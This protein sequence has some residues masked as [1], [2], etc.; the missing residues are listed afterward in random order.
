MLGNHDHARR[1]EAHHPS[2]R[3]AELDGLR[4]VAVLMVI[5]GH[6]KSMLPFKGQPWTLFL[7]PTLG[8]VIFFVLSG[9]LITRLLLN[10]ISRTGRV[11]LASFYWRRA[12]RILPA[13]YVYLGI[14]ALLAACGLVAIS[15]GQLLVAFLHLWNY[16]ALILGEGHPLQGYRNLGHFWS[17]ALEEQYYWIWPLVLILF[18]RHSK[19]ILVTIIAVVPV[20]RVASYFLFPSV[21]GQLG[22]MFHTGIDA[23]SV[24]SLIAVCEKTL[25]TRIAKLPSKVISAAVVALM[26]AVPILY[27][28][29]KGPWT[30]TYGRTVESMLAGLVILALVYRPEHWL[31]R[32]LRTKPMQFIGTISFSL[33][34]WQTAFCSKGAVFAVHPALSLPGAFAAAILSYYAVEKPAS[35]L[36]HMRLRAKV[37]TLTSHG[38]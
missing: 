36:R 28:L 31:S 9:F 22:M 30:M 37:V 32:C 23:I 2:Y 35:R 15:S 26:V 34:L 13:S 1:N 10:E 16:G 24:G 25:A 27:F 6:W 17:L 4:A 11:S 33:Y 19:L 3:I 8:V 12:I 20:I 7:N 5:F 38:T 14:M 21:R 18:V 29:A